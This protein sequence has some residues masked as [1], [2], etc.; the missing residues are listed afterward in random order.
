MKK[1]YLCILG[2]II[3]VALSV[4]SGGEAVHA[5]DYITCQADGTDAKDDS[6]VIQRYLDMARDN[7]SVR[8]KI[9]AGTYYLK[10]ALT[11]YSNT[12]LLLDRNAKII[13][14]NGSNVM[15]KGFQ[16]FKVTGYGQVHDV[17]IE[18][19]IWDG[20]ANDSTSLSPLMYFVHGQKVTLKNLTLQNCCGKHFAVLAGMD[21]CVVENVKFSNFIV[22]TGADPDHKYF[23]VTENGQIN[24]AQAFRTM[25]A[26]HLECISSDGKTETYAYPCDNT[27][28]KNITVKNCTF[29]NVM[30]AIGNH[31]SEQKNLRG[32]N[33]KIIGNTFKNVKYTC[34]NLYSQNAATIQ[35]NTT[36]NVGEFIRAV[37]SSPV[38][39]NNTVKCTGKENGDGLALCGMKFTDCT[40]IHVADNQIYNGLHG[41]YASF[42]T[43]KMMNNRVNT[44][45]QNG[46]TLLGGC[47]M[48]LSQNV[49]TGVGNMG[50][51]GEDSVV[52]AQTNTVN[53]AG[54]HG[55]SFMNS[56]VTVTGN[57]VYNVGQHGILLNTTTGEISENQVTKSG[58]NGVYIYQCKGSGQ[59]Q[60]QVKANKIATSGGRG[61]MVEESSYVKLLQ[62]RISNSSK[63]GI[64]I[65]TKSNQVTVNE[66][67][68]QTSKEHGILVDNSQ[69]VTVN[70]NTVNGS[71]KKDISI[72]NGSTG[73]GKDNLIWEGGVYSYDG[74]RF[75][76]HYRPEKPQTDVTIQF[77][78]IMIKAWYVESVQ[79]ALDHGIMKGVAEDQFQPN[80]PITRAQFVTVLHNLENKPATSVKNPFAD[81]KA[82]QW[83][84]TPILWAYEKKI[85]S[86]YSKT[87][88]GTNDAITREQLAK[89]LYV[90]ADLKKM[91]TNKTSG[92]IK[93][94]ADYKK[95]DDWAVEALDWA[96]T[97]GIMSGDGKNLNPLGKA[98]RA[99]CAAMMK[100]L[101]EKVK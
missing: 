51:Y 58:N 38:V 77:K 55:M 26:L 67:V 18:G 28:N 5:A 81:V 68:V 19:G 11:I 82:G 53:G 22:Y 89:M 95:A 93:K 78:D 25:E 60:V 16:D 46:I 32:Q 75:P 84:T 50:I 23:S 70:Q 40:G 14:T 83:Y 65:F 69:N 90:Y 27:A 97:R 88:F 61:I 63:Q 24:K 21:S 100:N 66:N 56:T 73:S 31:Y 6:A 8:V 33:L 4:L 54:K 12:E 30:C 36:Q 29:E 59:T 91:N 94:F 96:V 62:N 48:E 47:H 44:P 13:R 80:T 15:V 92:A 10:D 74:S 101:Q 52:I 20:D 87:Q 49:T 45:G 64:G 85:T 39:T 34:I 2:C 9:P 7:G 99:E 3:G 72:L 98:T 71:G 41:I 57:V 86:G 17:T 43:G 42:S 79:Y 76:V 1:K 35:R 37:N